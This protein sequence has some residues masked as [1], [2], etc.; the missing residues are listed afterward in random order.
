MIYLF[1]LYIFFNICMNNIKSPLKGVI[2]FELR[3]ISWKGRESG[4]D[5]SSSG[6]FVE[7]NIST[8]LASIV[9][10]SLVKTYLLRRLWAE[11]MEEGNCGFNTRLRLTHPQTFFRKSLKGVKN[12][13]CKHVNLS[14]S[15][16][17]WPIQ[18]DFSCKIVYPKP[19]SAL[20]I[21]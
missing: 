7:K 3:G 12:F 5:R 9:K 19:V 1:T 20:T 18:F 11:I 15:K 14:I 10:S 16:K 17:L 8:V 6:S 4:S 21:Y 13:T 2:T